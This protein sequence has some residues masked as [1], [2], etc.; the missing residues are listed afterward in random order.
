MP[1][2]QVQCPNC[3]RPVTAEVEQ[4]FDV[5]IDP[6][7]KQ[8]LLGG[9]VNTLRCPHCGY[10]G[11][12]ALPIIYHDPTKELLL[13]YFPPEL[14]V[15]L[16][17][18]EK[19]IA[20]LM[21]RVVNNLKQEERK[22]YL[23]KPQQMFTYQGLIEKVLEGEGITKEMLEAQRKRVEFLQSLMSVPEENLVERVKTDAANLDAEIFALLSRMLEAGL[24]ARDE[25]A[26]AKLGKIQEVLL[27]H[28][29]IGKQ[30]KSQ[31]DEIETA[32][33]SLE[34][35]GK[36]L[37]REKLLEMLIAAVDN[38]VRL[39]ALASMSRPGIDYVF[40]QTLSEQIDKAGGEEK[41]KLQ[42]LR[43]RLLEITKQIDDQLQQRLAIA[44]RNLET[45]LQSDKPGELLR[46]NAAVLDDFF[47]Q[48]LNQALAQADEKKD[49]DR[50][51]K[52]ETLLKTIQQLISP[53]Y[54]PELLNALLEA[55]NDEARKGVLEAHGNEVTSEFVE[56]L[57][58]MMLQLE[59]AEKDLA[60][61]VRAA[62]R[63]AL[64]FSM[65]K[66]LQS[67]EGMAEKLS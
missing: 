8:L 17:E 27:E 63:S 41:E 36:D 2:T 28:T 44:Q 22:A 12:L 7:A 23:F 13:T 24:A 58:A 30:I 26:V 15:P 51:Q 37:T 21:N 34:S 39:N 43:E 18:Q 16:M 3:K 59:G 20:P 42:K 57:S 60:D 1:R 29:E 5:G 9:V 53:G 33:A 40:F 46:Q 38:E 67:P 64:R 61:K 52:L 14:N 4:L 48:I 56:S 19:Q 54:N 32:R 25:G 65:E 35:A 10:Q 49:A 55:K 66:G 62:Y 31:A 6:Q 50:R 45:L 11:N 47:L